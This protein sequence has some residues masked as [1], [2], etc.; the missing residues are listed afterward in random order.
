MFYAV[1]A[2]VG[3]TENPGFQGVF[4]KSGSDGPKRESS[5][6]SRDK[7]D[8]GVDRYPV[9]LVGSPVFNTSGDLVA[10]Y[11]TLPLGVDPIADTDPK[12]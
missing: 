12:D 3:R 9:F 6:K 5:G 4:C 11:F 1:L 8:R 2:G 7:W 10:F